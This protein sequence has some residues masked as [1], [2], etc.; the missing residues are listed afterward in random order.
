MDGFKNLKEGE[1][2][3]PVKSQFGYHIIKVTGVTSEGADV[4]H[5]LVAETGESK[6]TPFDEVKDSIKSQLTNEKT[7]AAYTTK[8]EEWKKT[9]DIKTYENRL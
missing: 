8:L 6:V 3:Q 9:I 5:I 4:S 7:N 1:I 2:S